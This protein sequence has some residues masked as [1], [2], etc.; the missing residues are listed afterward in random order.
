[1]R[2]RILL[3]VVLALF[4][5]VP[6]ASSSFA[7]GGDAVVAKKKKKLSYCPGKAKKA[8]AKLKARVKS[9]KFFLYTT[10]RPS[11]YLFCAE[12]PKFNGWIAAW[13]G[14]KATSHVRAVRNNCAV[15]YS[16][17]GTEKSIKIV[18]FKFFRRG[19][20]LP[21]Q[22][23]ASSL[24]NT[25]QQVDFHQL[26]LASNCVSASTYVVDGAPTLSV[27]GHGDF[28]YQGRARHSIAGASVAE[29]KAVKVVATSP[30]TAQV[31]ITVGGVPRTIDYPGNAK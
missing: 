4:V 23:Q 14:I 2:T 18:P 9:A 16:Q 27:M 19:S 20:K 10:R 31:Q 17:T 13:E 1:M 21:K 6:L 3:S 7:S 26:V 11:E 29:M 8:K 5:A 25:G 15:F 12:S 30:T 24:N 22:T 28:E